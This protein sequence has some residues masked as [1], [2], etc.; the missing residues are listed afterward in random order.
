MNQPMFAAAA[1]LLFASGH[2]IKT[3]YAS[4][5]ALRVEVESTFSM[6]TTDFSMERDGEPVESRFGAGG[7]SS[8]TRRVVMQ[9]TVVEAADGE[10]S[11]V[12]R[13]FVEVSGSSVM[14]RGE[15]EFESER[16][17]PLHEVTL[18]LTLHEGEVVAEVVDG[19]SPDEEAT[20]EGHQL[21]LSLDALL[22]SEG[23]EEG[24]DW[25]L[26]GELL[27]AALM[28]DIEGALFP[29]PARTERGEGGEGGGGRGGRRGGRGGRGGGSAARY[30]NAGVWDAK[31]TLTEGTEEYAGVECLVISIEGECVGS[32]PER[33][34]GGGGGRR[35]GD[36]ALTAPTA[37]QPENS[38]ELEIEGKLYFDAES[39]HPV[40][41]ELE[42]MLST[43]SS[44][45]MNRGE[46]TMS[47]YTA[48]EGKFTHS[49]DVSRVSTEDD[50]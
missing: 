40:H 48:Q 14:S 16:E 18:E 46:S 11:S 5:S 21:T 24:D 3:H 10:P 31:A 37:L 29:P 45:E 25:E 42:G 23:V 26:D 4:E 30:V 35:G 49:V 22:P 50:E 28:M 2:E 17:C 33:E 20:L 9:D 39:K 44:R 15:E 47:M 32:V 27:K 13:E 6:E 19:D 1:L 41:L 7:G 8:E 43:E 34:R 12:R 36:R 38:F